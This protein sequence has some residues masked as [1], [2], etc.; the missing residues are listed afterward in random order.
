MI[1]L[2][3]TAYLA[4]GFASNDPWSPSLDGILAFWYLRENLGAEAFS[5]TSVDS[6]QMAPVTGLPLAVKRFGD[7]WWYQCTSPRYESRAEF[8]RYFHRRFDAEHAARYLPPHRAR[9]PTKAGPFKAYRLTTRVIVCDLIEWDAVGDIAEVR[10]LLAR[11]S[12]VGHKIGHGNGR[13]LRWDV[14]PVDADADQWPVLAQRPLPVEYA[15]RAGIEGPEML[16][17]LR[18][19]VRITQ[20]QAVCVMPW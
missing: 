16:W 2:R 20:N 10:R 8:L 9:I 6:S 5:A 7:Q 19:P 12:A 3:V 11:C 15:A 13:V 18:P 1:P 4:N 14:A 17:G